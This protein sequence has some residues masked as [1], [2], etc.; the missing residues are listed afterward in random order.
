MIRKAQIALLTVSLLLAAGGHYASVA[1][2]AEDLNPTA[3]LGETPILF[4]VRAPDRN[5]THHYLNQ[6]CFGGK[7]GSA[8]K[9]LDPPT[10]KT[11]VLVSAPD[12]IIRRPCVN[13]DGKRILFSMCMTPKGRFHIYEIEVDPKTLF[14]DT[15]EVTPKQLTF[16]PDVDDVDPI[17]LADGKIAFCSS[18][19][20]K[21]VPCAGQ[22]CPQIFRMDG[23]G[24]NIHQITRS[25]VHENE[26]S[27]MPD[28][29]ILYNRWDYV[30]RNFGDGH[31]FWV[32]N[33]DGCNQAIVYG[34]NTAHPAAPWT[35][36]A[37]PGTGKIICSLG[38]HHKSLGGAMAIINPRVAVDGYA[39]IERTWPADVIERFRP[40]EVPD[41]MPQKKAA[42]IGKMQEIWPKE[43]KALI[44]TS[45]DF[46]LHVK[47]DNLNSVRP[48]YNCPFPL[49]DSHFLYVVSTTR[50]A[51]AAIYL[52]DIAG[53]E[54]KLYEE[55]PGCYDPMPLAASP[56]P[57]PLSSPRD[58]A[59]NDGH[60]YIQNVYVGTHTAA[61]KPGSVK[62]VRVV[63]AHS[64]RGKSGHY[65]RGLGHQEGA[66][67]WTGFL[68]KTILGT[69]PVEE[70][71]SASFYAPADR[72]LYFQLL[73]E[74]G[75]M[76]H[77]MRSG[78]SI[79]SGERRG[80]V[81]CHESRTS[82]AELTSSG[83]LPIALQREP[84]TLTPWQGEPRR[85]NYLTEVQPIF[86]KHCIKCH[87]FGKKAA[88][89]LILAGD[90]NFAFN[91]SYCELQS[92]GWT[93]A[94]GAGPAAHLPALSW[95]SHTSPLIKHLTRNCDEDRGAKLSEKEMN[96]LA[97]WIDLNAP[98]YPTGYS[99]RPGGKPGRSPLT[100]QET[101]RFF[102]LT[103][104]NQKDMSYA[105]AYRGPQVS[106][107]RPELSPC[108]EKIEDLEAR[109]EV[110]EII[111]SGK[112]S[113]E[114]LPR[115][116]MP[117]FDK[118]YPKDEER[119]AHIEKY[120]QLEQDV[121]KAIR[122]GEK[123]YDSPEGEAITLNVR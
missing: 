73:D 55:A 84:S 56:R 49:S 58:F 34:N 38:T 13:F 36:R 59:N 4:T 72:F 62:Y 57:Q 52:G 65:W 122:N 24:A 89:K 15:E 67:G 10:G 112:A 109:R 108:L 27:L 81:G 118:L 3:V 19:D 61:I 69:A 30:D 66:I 16:A 113:L 120:R 103:D 2:A 75:M 102:K 41:D 37:I 98:Y 117:G 88:K 91:V 74:N 48:W 121:R 96:T 14:A 77:S 63:Q 119:R 92:K 100:P 45:S 64:K 99:A 50:Q 101:K 60:F 86:D 29:R 9:V 106:F 20:F 22:T 47:Q 78:T 97:T 23:D 115:A 21:I 71:G 93:G 70:D 44:P 54:I 82:S 104:L 111:A 28:G 26:L 8:L 6:A 51:K 12:G 80:C 95:G 116:D 46:V 7:V 110:L 42:R 43:A 18:R 31:G 76:I 94:I 123:I 79:H 1:L 17:Y 40:Q 85:F 105:G 53:N 114:E 107:D 33:P 90:K 5:G 35:A 83:T 39:P 11:R 32:T 68:A 87:D 25:T